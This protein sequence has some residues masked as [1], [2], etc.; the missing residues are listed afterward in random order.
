MA[1]YIELK[2]QLAELARQAEEAKAVEVQAVIDDIRAKVAEYGLM[3][4]DIFGRRR[5]AQAER[6]FTGMPKYRD[7]KTGAQ[8]T[9]HGRAPG[10]I[11]DVKDRTK[12]LIA[13]SAE[14]ASLKHTNRRAAGGAATKKPAAKSVRRRARRGGGRERER[15]GDRLEWASTALDSMVLWATAVCARRWPLCRRWKHLPATF[16]VSKEEQCART[17]RLPS[18]NAYIACSARVG[19]AKC[20]HVH[21]RGRGEPFFH[22]VP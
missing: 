11:K 8:W 7:P 19:A 21:L 9:G 20:G 12:F 15:A 13:G 5:R 4:M 16:A 6:A 14:A 22:L 18:L 10:W 3:E 1:T 17:G 2:A